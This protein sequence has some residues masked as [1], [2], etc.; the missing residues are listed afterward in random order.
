[1]NLQERIKEISKLPDN[2]RDMSGNFWN[3]K[4]FRLERWLVGSQLCWITIDLLMHL[5]KLDEKHL[6][7]AICSMD[8]ATS[9]MCADFF[10]SGWQISMYLEKGYYY[11]EL[12]QKVCR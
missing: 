9:L 10:F 12:G 1:M 7:V 3:E 11:D 8:A 6:K 4:Q 2:P 5:N